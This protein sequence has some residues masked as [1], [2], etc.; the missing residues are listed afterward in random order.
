MLARW[1]SKLETYDYK[2][3][4]RSGVK[5]TNADALS[6]HRASA[7]DPIVQTVEEDVL[8]LDRDRGATACGLS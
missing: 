6:S 5:H 3:E 8:L 4:H 7:K 1:I 2:L